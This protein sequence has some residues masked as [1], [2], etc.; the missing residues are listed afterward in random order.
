MA[1]GPLVPNA[2]KKLKLKLKFKKKVY[3]QVR[4]KQMFKNLGSKETTH[5]S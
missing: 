2:L 5:I 3:I 4:Q 1:K